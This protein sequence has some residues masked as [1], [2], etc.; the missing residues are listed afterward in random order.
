MPVANE[1]RTGPRLTVAVGLWQIYL[2]QE[3]LKAFEVDVRNS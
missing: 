2:F 3:L 1:V